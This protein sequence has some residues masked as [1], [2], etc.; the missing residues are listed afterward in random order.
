MQRRQETAAME[1]GKSRMHARENLGEP[2]N[3]DAM[4]DK[5]LVDQTLSCS[6]SSHVKAMEIAEVELATINANHAF[7]RWIVC[8][9]KGAGLKDLTV[10]DVLVLHHINHRARNKRLADICFVLNI[11]DTH[12]AVY[13]IRK[14]IGLDLINSDKHGKE[15]TYSTTALGQQY[16]LRYLEIREHCLLDA[17]QTLNLSKS[18]LE[19]LAQYLRRMSGLYDQAARAVSSI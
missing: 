7:Q 16:L 1:K 15:V 2:G 19:E 12:V 4:I 10:T 9:M 17:M 18:V 13:S 5:N 8:C 3:I 11:E 14:L 6:T